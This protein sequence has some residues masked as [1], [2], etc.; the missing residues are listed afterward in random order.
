MA[1]SGPSENTACLRDQ[2]IPCPVA[3]NGGGGGKFELLVTGI[4]LGESLFLS[5]FRPAFIVFVTSGT[6]RLQTFFNQKGQRQS[7]TGAVLQW[8]KQ[9]FA[10]ETR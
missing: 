10:G 4:F 6:S 7:M 3:V 9:R 5:Y 2:F 1:H 8:T